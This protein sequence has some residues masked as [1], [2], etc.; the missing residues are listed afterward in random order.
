MRTPSH[1]RPRRRTIDRVHVA[2]LV[3]LAN[4]AR[5]VGSAEHKDYPSPAGLPRLRVDATKCDPRLHGDFE[6]LTGWLQ[7][8]IRVGNVGAPWEGDFPRYSASTRLASQTRPCT[9]NGPP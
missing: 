1:R 7:A 2:N 8:A 5:Y 4:E 9:W 3:A 6:M